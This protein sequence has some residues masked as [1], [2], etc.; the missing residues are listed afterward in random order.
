MRAKRVVTVPFQPYFGFQWVSPSALWTFWPIALI[1]IRGRRAFVFLALLLL[2]LVLF[3]LFFFLLFLLL[4]LV[5]IWWQWLRAILVLGSGAGWEQ[6]CTGRPVI[7]SLGEGRFRALGPKSEKKSPTNGSC[8]L[9]QNMESNFALFSWWGQNRFL[10]DSVFEFGGPKSAFFQARKLTSLSY[11]A[12]S[13]FSSSSRCFSIAGIELKRVHSD[14]A[15]SNCSSEGS[16]GEILEALAS[17]CLNV[18][19]QF[20]SWQVLSRGPS[21]DRIARSCRHTGPDLT[22]KTEGVR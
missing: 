21:G 10:G 9:W 18:E 4:L 19:W 5:G 6:C 17:G 11:D 15:N 20:H 14:A 2:V 1:L 7:A 22:V 3:S 13:S 16:C 8:H 12:R